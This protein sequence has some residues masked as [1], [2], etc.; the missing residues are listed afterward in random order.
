MREAKEMVQPGCC[1]ACKPENLSSNP[2]HAGKMLSVAKYTCD[3][4]TGGGQV[5][6][7]EHFCS[8]QA[9]QSIQSVSSRFSERI[10]IRK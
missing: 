10:D 5:G 3:P 8:L 9:S 6:R 7:Q 4:V 1:S 2:Q